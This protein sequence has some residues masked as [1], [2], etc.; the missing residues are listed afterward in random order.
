MFDRIYRENLWDG[1]ESRSGLGSGTDGIGSLPDEIVALVGEL[2]VESVLDV[3][4]GD[5]FWMPDLPGYI[6]LDV[7][8]VAL[9]MARERH[10]DRD[11]RLD[12]GSGYPRADLVICRCVMQHMTPVEGV[13]MLI[14]IEASGARWLLATTYLNGDNHSMDRP[15]GEGGGYWAN[16]QKDPFCMPEPRLVLE[17]GRTDRMRK[18]CVLALWDLAQEE[19]TR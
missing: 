2:G 17:D 8:E 15:I 6:G 5:G 18:G 9:D 4:C 1:G 12:D 3:G 7:S 19:R 14:D 10:P 11:Y 13:E 16:L